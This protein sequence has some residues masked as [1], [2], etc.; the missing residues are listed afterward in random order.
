[1]KTYK[2]RVVRLD[3]SPA[4]VELGD[5]EEL[6]D[7]EAKYDASNTLVAMQIVIIE[8]LR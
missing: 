2:I 3:D 1:M 5:G 4:V 7:A 6:F 8:E